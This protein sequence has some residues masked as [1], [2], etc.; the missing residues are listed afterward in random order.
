MARYYEGVNGSMQG[1]AGGVNV[2]NWRG[3]WIQR[4]RR[5][6]V[7]N[8]VPTADQTAVIT[9]FSGL[10]KK[11][12]PFRTAFKAAILNPP[13]GQTY[14]SVAAKV[15]YAIQKTKHYSASTHIINYD[16]RDLALGVG[17]LGTLPVT[18]SDGR[19]NVLSF[20]WD[21][22][23][24]QSPLLGGHLVAVVYYEGKVLNFTFPLDAGTATASYAGIET[25]EGTLLSVFTCAASSNGSTTTNY[26]DF[27]M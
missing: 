21:A 11:L 18:V 10:S 8:F 20:T 7:M 26:T 4:A 19:D 5:K 12:K 1:T 25:T 22:P 16:V 9:N 17:S 13:V 27:D 23:D 14:A 3:R 2:Y 24:L 15:N 6:S